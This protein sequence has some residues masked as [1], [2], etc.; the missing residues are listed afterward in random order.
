M[1]VMSDLLAEV[2]VAEVRGDALAAQVDAVVYDSRR[3]VDRALF[4]CVPGANVDG[5][6]FAAAAVAQGAGSLLCEHFL[7]LAV[8][9]VRVAPGTV[10]TAMAEVA[11]A[12]WGHPARSLAMFG[13]TGTNGKTTVTQLV[14]SILE[15]AG[16]PTGVIGTLGGV[17]TTPE[18]PDLQEALAR[19]VASG[20]TAA[21]MEVSSHALSQGRVDGIVFDVAAF[22]NLSRDHL[23]HHGTMEAYFGAK[24]R[25]FDADRCRQA[26]VLVGTPWGD[27]LAGL[28]GDRLV[29]VRR[30]D[31]SDV[32][33]S[34]A[35]TSFL[36]RG[37]QV[38]LPLAGRFNV[39]NAL[40][41]A[42]SAVAL[43]VDEETVVAGL[44]RAPAV[45]GRMEVV[46]GG[47]PVSVVVD[48]AHTPDGLEVALGAARQLA[49]DGRVLCVFGC[50]GDRDPGKRPLM[51]RVAADLADVVVVTSDNPRSEDPAGISRAIVS[52]MAGADPLVVLDRAE[53]IG[54]AVDT[55]RPGD[56]VLI[57]GKGHETTQ[58]T[59]SATV[60][61]DDRAEAA[62]ALVR[63]F[64]EGSR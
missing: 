41:A 28:V 27:R 55:A 46:G 29:T 16:R 24:R 23:D 37:R 44:G 19:F 33:T 11:A 36:W 49:G 61:F 45:P 53:A 64:G 59:G 56:L 43:G 51:G 17:R 10:R 38:A 47:A 60:P 20:R 34:V 15:A 18:A 22:T 25:L 54:L 2:P 40:V 14:R 21:A 50:G 7:D 63:R 52:G 4:C 32:R 9:Q 39:D 31:A 42:A 57:A 62:A 3:S 12:F 58:T 1:A 35:G 8:P 30:E 5:H 6:D 26:V 13:V 48:Y